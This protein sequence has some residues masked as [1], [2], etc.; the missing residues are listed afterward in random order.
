LRDLTDI[1]SETDLSY[2]YLEFDL[3]K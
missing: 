3:S 2:D 1:F